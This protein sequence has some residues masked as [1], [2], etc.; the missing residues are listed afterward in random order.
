METQHKDLAA[1]RWFTMS[2]AEQ[3]GNVGS[4]VGRAVKWRNQ[5]NLENQEKA[6]IRA[7]ELLDLTIAD[8]R[9]QRTPRL[10]ELCRSREM[11]G[12]AF[13]GG[14]FKSTP[15]AIEKYFYWYAI[16]ARRI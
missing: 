2:L 4:E 16:E 9:W 7:Y 12:E 13:Y 8:Y 15:E 10:K 11:L 14:D 5:G 6:L 3:L 1:G